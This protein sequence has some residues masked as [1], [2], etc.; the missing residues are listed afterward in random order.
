MCEVLLFQV[1]VPAVTSLL[2]ATPHHRQTR[3]NRQ[4]LAHSDQRS[5]HLDPAA[6][7]HAACC[8]PAQGSSGRL[9]QLKEQRTNYSPTRRAFLAL[10]LLTAQTWK[11]ETEKG[12]T[13][14]N[15]EEAEQCAADVCRLSPS[16]ATKYVPV[17]YGEVFAEQSTFVAQVFA[18]Q[19]TFVAQLM[20]L[21]LY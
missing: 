21:S 14:G 8:S 19:S 16:A 4:Q 11:K 15:D 2:G 3:S 5:P 17:L 12:V 13:P 9:L 6:A 7:A 10:P 18:E 20:V 1:L